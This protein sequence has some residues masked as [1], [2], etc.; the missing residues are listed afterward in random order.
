M[1]KKILFVDDSPSM[2]KV[3]FDAMTTQGF[4]VT[5]AKD[6]IDGVNKLNSARFDLIISDLNMPN[7][8][9]IEFIKKVKVHPENKYSP[10]I[11]LTTDSNNEM[12]KQGQ[13][14]GAKVWVVKPFRE[15]QLVTVANKLLGC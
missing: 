3:M 4:T 13:A 8:N 6:G 15:E 11:M 10:I 9:G 14:A 12:K 5:T 2:R 7:M 1:L